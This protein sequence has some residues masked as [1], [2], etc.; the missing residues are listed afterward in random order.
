MLLE[1]SV[2]LFLNSQAILAPFK[3]ALFSGKQS[4]PSIFFFTVMGLAET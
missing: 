4:D 1:D 2:L 3:A